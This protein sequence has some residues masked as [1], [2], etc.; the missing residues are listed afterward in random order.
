MRLFVGVP[1][2]LKLHEK[3]HAVQKDIEQSVKGSFVSP[4]NF[5]FTA[6]FLGD[7]GEGTISDICSHIDAVLLKHS[8][9][10]VRLIGLGAFPSVKHLRVV[11]VGTSENPAFVSLLTVI[12][13]ALG[14][15]RKDNYEAVIPHL[16]LVRVRGVS[17]QQKLEM[18]F[19]KFRLFDF[20]SF[21][22]GNVVLYR[23]DLGR[24]G[25][26]YTIVR[27]FVLGG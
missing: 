8:S 20:G 23:S 18:T 4:A 21:T 9:F 2:P 24:A 1:I 27:E 11:W 13:R 6:K 14:S 7:V 10:P 26:V 25:P 15:F 12:Q 16:T 5:H 19:K 22:V 3:L 17:D